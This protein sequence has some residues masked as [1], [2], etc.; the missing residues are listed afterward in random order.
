MNRQVIWYRGHRYTRRTYRHT[1]SNRTVL[2]LLVNRWQKAEPRGRIMVLTAERTL[3][4]SA[5]SRLTSD[6]AGCW[7]DGHW[8]QY[9]VAHMVNRAE[10]LGY[11]DAEVISLADRHIASMGRSEDPGLTD[12]EYGILHDASDDVEAW[13]NEHVAPEGHYFGWSDGK[14]FLGSDEWWEESP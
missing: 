14:F 7:V 10:E 3:S 12:D 13:L 4:V 6:D 5:P 8:G 1:E 11:D 2:T 9:A